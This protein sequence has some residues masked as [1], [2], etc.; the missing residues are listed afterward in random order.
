M[1]VARALAI[2][3]C[4]TGCSSP[5]SIADAG[6]DSG[7]PDATQVDA[8]WPVDAN[9]S[10]ACEAVPLDAAELTCGDDTAS[11]PAD[12]PFCVSL[13]LE[14]SF[15]CETCCGPYGSC[16]ERL[17]DDAV[18]SQCSLEGDPNCPAGTPICCGEGGHLVCYGRQLL[19]WRCNG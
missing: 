6:N 16:I 13:T 15:H 2:A 17:P 4:A 14:D 9:M 19:G 1:V 7:A 18:V 12:R 11:C 3:I 5:P 10:D 8:W